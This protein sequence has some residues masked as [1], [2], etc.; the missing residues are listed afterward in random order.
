MKSEM[1][2]KSKKEDFETKKDNK[3]SKMDFNKLKKSENSGKSEKKR[4]RILLF[5][6]LESM[7]GGQTGLVAIRKPHRLKCVV[8]KRAS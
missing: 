1:D 8:V 4:L 7:N 2:G 6:L 5:H 3:E